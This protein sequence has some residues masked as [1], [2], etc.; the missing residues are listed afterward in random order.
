MNDHRIDTLAVH[1]GQ[2]LDKETGSRAVPIYQTTSFVFDDA[3]DAADRFA[4]KKFG[5][6]YSRLGN[7][8]CDAI[9]RRIAGLEGGTS[10]ISASSGMAAVFHAVCTL[11][12]AGQNFVTGA[13]LYGGTHTLFRHTLK[14][15]G[16]EARFVDSSNPANFEK[17]VDDKTRLLFTES[18]G[19]PRGN[20]DDLA[21]I[22]AVAKK[23]G[24]PFIV[25][26]TFT[27][28][29]IFRPFEHGADIVVHS[30]TKMI[31]GHGTTIGG[32]VV[33][34]GDFNWA[35]GKFPEFTA[36]DPSYHGLVYWDAFGGHPKAVAPGIAFTTKIRT[37]LLRDIGAALAPMNAFLLLQGAESLPLRAARHCENARALAQWLE[38]H[39]KV[40]WV[41]Y[42]GLPSHGDYARAKKLMPLG[43][44]AVYGFGV[45]GGRD[46]GKRFI[47][48]VRLASHLANVLDAKTLVIHPA[49]TTHSQLTEAELLAGGVRPEMIRL[50]VGIEDI[51]DIQADFDQALS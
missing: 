36:P 27:P 41:A 7:P 51:R 37:G 4:L 9:E 48:K 23:H 31:G 46:A 38:K 34:K 49:S 6:I 20:V 13:N 50:S 10:A 1:A 35:N 19:N 11:A 25:D 44:G 8:T 3:Q 5:P 40:E 17:A 42:A 22:A 30:C 39:P 18:V 16:I 43:P 2:T 14:R 28:P 32:M 29:P 26:N 15:F 45:K 47:G 12:Q 33:E 24:L 21:G